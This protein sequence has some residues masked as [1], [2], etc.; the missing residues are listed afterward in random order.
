MSA[1]STGAS[2]LAGRYATALFDLA[3]SDKALDDVA[4]D[5]RQLAEMVAGSGDLRRLMRSPTLSR[6]DQGRAMA[7]VADKAGFGDLTKRFLGIV[8][9]HR[10]LFALAAMIDAFLAQLAARRGE[11]AAEVASAGPLS[12][13]QLAGIGDA[14]R[15]ATGSK[16]TI[17]AQVDARLLGGLVVKIGSRMVDASLR[18]KLQKL[19]IA[20][21]GLG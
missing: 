5:L 8:A 19:Q 9:R 7:A 2:G 16:V 13:A 15:Q 11:L 1:D 14:L 3:E 4:G 18:T 12:E 10:R 20:M 21:K 6:A 17:S